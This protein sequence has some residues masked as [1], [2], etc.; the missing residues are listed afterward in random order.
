MKE[1]EANR[2][3]LR[4]LSRTGDWLTFRERFLSVMHTAVELAS[5]DL[6]HS[7]QN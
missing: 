5:L 2:H 1:G 7:P 3:A 4:K 6:E